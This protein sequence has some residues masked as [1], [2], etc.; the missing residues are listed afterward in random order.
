ML[1]IVLDCAMIFMF[2][3]LESGLKLLELLSFGSGSGALRFS[4]KSFLLLG[5][6]KVLSLEDIDLCLECLD[7]SLVMLVLI[8]NLMVVVIQLIL[9]IQNSFI[10]F[11]DFLFSDICHT[12][13]HLYSGCLEIIKLIFQLLVRLNHLV[14]LLECFLIFCLKVNCAS[15]VRVRVSTTVEGLTQSL[16]LLLKKL[17][18]LS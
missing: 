15:T 9:F 17:K 8:L 2:F 14:N 1:F 3:L 11:E 16:V 5:Q 6:V 7:L 10:G 12:P 4:F 18:P 13:L